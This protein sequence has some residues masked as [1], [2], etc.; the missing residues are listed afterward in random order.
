MFCFVLFCSVWFDGC[1]AF[2]FERLQGFVVIY[3][4]LVM[5]VLLVYVLV[6]LFVCLFVCLLAYLLACLLV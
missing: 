6:C 3:W 1:V 4:L 5:F 2:S